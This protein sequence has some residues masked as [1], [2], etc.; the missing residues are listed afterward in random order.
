MC[1]HNEKIVTKVSKASVTGGRVIAVWAIIFVTCLIMDGMQNNK[2][3]AI[4]LVALQEAVQ[5]TAGINMRRP[6]SLT[7][8]MR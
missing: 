7:F 8:I 1:S 3:L 5:I 4:G 6:S 2:C